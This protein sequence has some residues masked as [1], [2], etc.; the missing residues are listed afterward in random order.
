MNKTSENQLRKVKAS[1]SWL[2]KMKT[3]QY[4]RDFTFLVD[5]P[6]KLGGTNEGPTPLEYVI[7]AFNGCLLVVI[8]MVAKEQQFLFKDVV[9]ESYGTVDRRGL[10]GIA[11][12]L[13]HFQKVVNNITFVTEETNERLDNLQAEVQKRCPMYNLLVDAG[14]DVQLNWHISD[15]EDVKERR[16]V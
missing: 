13:P 3:R 10:L 2:G 7:G 8:E 12:V 9:I 16:N 15:E 1:S 14:I 11:D 6:E 5:E 4:V